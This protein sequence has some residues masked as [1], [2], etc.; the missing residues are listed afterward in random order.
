MRQATNT[1]TMGV[2]P[3]VG[4]ML[5]NHASRDELAAIYNRH[6]Y[7]QE[8]REAVERWSSHVLGITGSDSGEVVELKPGAKGGRGPASK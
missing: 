8:R 7:Q 2:S 5:L 6:E 4:E 1:K 3:E